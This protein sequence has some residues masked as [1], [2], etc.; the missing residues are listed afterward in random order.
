MVE[1]QGLGTLAFHAHQGETPTLN[2]CTHAQ[3]CKDAEMKGLFAL[4]EGIP[5]SRRNLEKSEHSRHR[6]PYSHLHTC[7]VTSHSR[8]I[9]TRWA[10]IRAHPERER[11]IPSSIQRVVLEEAGSTARHPPHSSPPIPGGCRA[12]AGRE[13]AAPAAAAGGA[14]AVGAA[15]NAPARLLRRE[16]VR[17]AAAGKQEGGGGCGGCSRGAERWRRRRS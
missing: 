13:T 10:S 12:S 3:V 1:P 9:P 4:K 8:S 16:V 6:G 14:A 7:R 5:T 15:G 2:I 17:S 11:D